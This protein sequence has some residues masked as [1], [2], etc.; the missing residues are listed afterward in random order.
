VKSKRRKPGRFQ[1]GESGNVR[2]RPKGSRNKSN[3]ELNAILDKCV[4]F[5][6]LICALAKEAYAG[7]D[8]CAKL[9]LEHRYGKP[10]ERITLEGEKT[11]YSI[12]FGNAKEKDD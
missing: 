7:N 4:D 1:K 6:K 9:L 5:E 10:R 12:T 2:G 3:A 11:L 8:K